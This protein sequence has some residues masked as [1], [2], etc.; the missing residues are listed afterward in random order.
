MQR[1]DANLSF[2]KLA[3]VTPSERTLKRSLS[4]SFKPTSQ[5]PNS[6]SSSFLVTTSLLDMMGL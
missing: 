5:W 1:V 2:Q 6:R 4:G 3:D